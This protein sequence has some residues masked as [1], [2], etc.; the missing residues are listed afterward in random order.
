LKPISPIRDLNLIW[1]YII[2][3][4]EISEKMESKF[5][6][7]KIP[8]FSLNISVSIIQFIVSENLEYNH[9]WIEL[10]SETSSHSFL[11]SKY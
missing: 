5:S 4:Q 2:K 8:F 10:K 6:Y 3:T 9:E 1:S 11:F 7:E